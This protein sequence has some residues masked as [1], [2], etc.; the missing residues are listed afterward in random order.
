MAR[1][2]KPFDAVQFTRESAERVA[3]VVRQAELSPAAASPLTFD[4]R[5][6]DR[7]PKQVRA[8]TFTG[9]WNT[10]SSK[11]VTFANNPAGTASVLNLTIVLPFTATQNCIV[12]RDGTSWYLVSALDEQV[13]RGT[14]T[15]SWPIGSSKN[16]TFK[17][18][19]TTPNT[20]AVQN[21]LINLPSAGTRNCV[22]GREGTAWHLINWQWDIAYAATA[23]T[24]T[25]TSLRFDTLPFAAVSTS[26]TVTFSVSVATCS[27]A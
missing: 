8:A 16:V 23:A 17:Y 25:T 18:Q 4:R 6:S 22:I 26:S 12:G 2:K 7:I 3:R 15:G 13:R 14:F 10:G 24:L 19:T 11:V 5:I 1:Q 20:V 21:D 9:S 27:T